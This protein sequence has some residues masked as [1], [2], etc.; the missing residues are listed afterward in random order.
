M[1]EK[2]GTTTL[3]YGQETALNFAVWKRRFPALAIG[4]RTAKAT[5][6][7]AI[8]AAAVLH[9]IAITDEHLMPN[10]EIPFEELL[11]AV[12]A[13][14]PLEENDGY[15]ARRALIQHHFL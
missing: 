3:K 5:T 2:S 7:I 4:M 12:D 11:Q 9:N 10:P 8:V 6:L 13:V 14:P 1:A 15:G